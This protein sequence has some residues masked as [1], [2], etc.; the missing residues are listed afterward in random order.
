MENVSIKLID[1]TSLLHLIDKL[2]LL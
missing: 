2:V 1:L